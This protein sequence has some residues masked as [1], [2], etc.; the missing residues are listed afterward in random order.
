MSISTSSASD[1]LVDLLRD[2]GIDV[3]LRYGAGPL[4]GS[5]APRPSGL[6]LPGELFPV[7]SPRLLDGDPP[8]R[9]PADLGAPCPDVVG[10]AAGRH[11]RRR[12]TDRGWAGLAG[13]PPA[14]KHGGCCCAPPRAR[15]PVFSSTQL[16]RSR[17]PRPAKESSLAPAILVADDIASG[18][19]VRPLRHFDFPIPSASGFCFAPTARRRSRASM[20]GGGGSVTRPSRSAALESSI[21]AV[22][23]VVTEYRGASRRDNAVLTMRG[24]SATSSSTPAKPARPKDGAAAGDADGFHQGSCR[25]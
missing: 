20:P 6:W 14:P 12:Q 24:R 22:R 18:R 5:R 17:P 13:P 2:P 23:G 11:G 1:A 4:C 10:D 21:P 3:A 19:L 16:S 8:L 15:P 25:R 7:C 9:S